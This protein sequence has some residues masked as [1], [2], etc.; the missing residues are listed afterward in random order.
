LDD[1]IGDTFVLAPRGMKYAPLSAKC[2]TRTLVLGNTFVQL[3]R[4]LASVFM[5]PAHTNQFSMRQRKIPQEDTTMQSNA[6]AAPGQEGV[7]FGFEHQPSVNTARRLPLPPGN[8]SLS[9]EHA[10]VA[11][12]KSGHHDAFG[13]LYNRHQRQAYRTAFRIL[14]NQQDAEDAVQRAFQRAFVNLQR[15]REDSTFS[16]WLTR[17][18]VNDALMLLRQRRRREPLHENSVDAAPDDVRAEIADGRPTPEEI[19]CASERRATVRQAVAK[20]RG[21]LKVV[22]LYGKLQGLT[23]AETA[24]RLGLTVSAVEARTFHARRF[25][26]KQLEPNF[27]RLSALSTPQERRA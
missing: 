19:L 14:R 20:L 26:R 5:H 3:S 21:S 13:E 8:Q 16:T 7:M 27:K 17:I 11:K 1:G 12:A 15:F 4:F 9:D 10:L 23:S 24:R 22:V 6:T 18:V 25:L 2:P